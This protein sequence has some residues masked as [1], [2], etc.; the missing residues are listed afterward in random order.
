MRC[1]YLVSLPD[2]VDPAAEEESEAH[3]GAHGGVHALTVAAGGEDG[4][5]LAGVLAGHQLPA[6]LGHRRHRHLDR[7]CSN[8]HLLVARVQGCSISSRLCSF[9][10]NV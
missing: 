4:D 3:D 1:T 8:R 6:P 7:S 9:A 10:N 2:K 5:A